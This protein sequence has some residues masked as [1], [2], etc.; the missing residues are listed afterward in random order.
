MASPPFAI[1][2][3]HPPPEGIPVAGKLDHLVKEFRSLASS[4]CAAAASASNDGATTNCDRMYFM[5]ASQCLRLVKG[6]LVQ[7]EDLAHKKDVDMMLK[8]DDLETALAAARE[9][10]KKLT[11]DLKHSEKERAKAVERARA[12]EEKMKAVSEQSEKDR[13]ELV[14]EKKRVQQLQRKVDEFQRIQRLSPREDSSDGE[15]KKG[16]ETNSN[17]DVAGLQRG[18]EKAKAQ[19]KKKQDEYQLQAVSL[20]QSNA[21][22]K[23]L[24]AKISEDKITVD[25]RNKQIE[26]LEARIEE[27]RA[28]RNSESL[29]QEMEHAK[30]I[31]SMKIE[32]ESRER[33][34]RAEN[35]AVMRQSKQNAEKYKRAE[36]KASRIQIKLV[37]LQNTPIDYSSYG[38]SRFCIYPFFTHYLTR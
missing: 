26:R 19:L 29:S 36:E 34:L 30:K 32:F 38:V 35:A 15:K 33:E 21:K 11:Q 1:H 16:K 27:D 10:R 20:Q 9:E 18:L 14:K 12:T 22:N 17:T 5:A 6:E 25:Q 8:V 31:Q 37:E 13:A 23:T 3:F 2:V 4:Q 7:K 28:Q 24:E